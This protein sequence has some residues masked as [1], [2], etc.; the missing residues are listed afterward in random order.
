MVELR[1]IRSGFDGQL[2]VCMLSVIIRAGGVE[3]FFSPML[4]TCAH[5][6]RMEQFSGL[7]GKV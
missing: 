7:E 2:R 6:R 1:S 4:S 5:S 3:A